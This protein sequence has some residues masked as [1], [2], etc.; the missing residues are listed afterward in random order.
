MSKFS[1]LVILSATI[2]LF[3]QDC[4]KYKKEIDTLME[5]FNAVKE[6]MS[7]PGITRD[8]YDDLY[9]IYTMTW[10]DIVNLQKEQKK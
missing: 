3:S 1:V 2:M 10:D 4:D 9:S 6:K 7:Q 5:E 8:E